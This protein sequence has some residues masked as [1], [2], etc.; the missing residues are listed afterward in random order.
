M[1]MGFLFHSTQTDNNKGLI[2][3]LPVVVR[4]G[5]AGTG[6]VTTTPT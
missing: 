4:I 6:V 1:R 2:G 3:V 5:H